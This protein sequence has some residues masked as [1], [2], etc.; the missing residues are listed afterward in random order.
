VQR[1]PGF[2]LIFLFTQD[3]LD[4]HFDLLYPLIARSFYREAWEPSTGESGLIRLA[5]PGLEFQV[6]LVDLNQFWLYTSPSD[7]TISYGGDRHAFSWLVV[8]FRVD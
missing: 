5:F 6:N 1:H 7:E 8:I 2:D 3:Q 4:R